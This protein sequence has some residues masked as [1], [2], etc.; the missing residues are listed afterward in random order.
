[1]S[2]SDPFLWFPRTKLIPP[3][4]GGDVLPRPELAAALRAAA[5]SHRLTLLS[6]P[7]GSGKT[8]AVAAL[9]QSYPDLPLAWITLDAG[10]DDPAAFLALLVAALQELLPG[11]A[12]T[13]A[14]LLAG[15]PEMARELRAAARRVVGALVNDLLACDPPDFLLVLDD[16]HVLENAAVL[17]ALDYLLEHLPPAMH[18]A[19]ACRH[20]PALSL[21]RLRAQGHLAEFRLDALRL[22]GDE[23]AR[24][25]NDVMGLGLS[26]AHLRRLQERTEGWVAGMRLLALS[27]EQLATAERDRFIQ[28]FSRSHRYIFDYLVEEVWQQQEPAMRDFL[29]ETSVL[30][31]L[32]PDLCRSVTGRPDAAQLLED[33]HRRNLFL[34]MGDPA[35]PAYR[36]HALFAHFLRSRL[37]RER[38][39]AIRELHRRAAQA[40][41]RAARAIPHYLAAE[42]WPF[43]ARLGLHP[44]LSPPVDRRAPR[45]R[46]A[47]APLAPARPR[48]RRRPE[49]VY[50]AGQALLRPRPEALSPGRGQAG[51][52]PGPSAIPRRG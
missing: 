31:E 7:A 41:T 43:P 44:D 36:Y 45:E 26:E 6:A 34:V 46:P 39:D 3:Q 47:G 48:R 20:D 37:R 50:G 1:M 22:T 4:V 21:A 29:L 27:L 38:P 17:R 24:W 2:S 51:R 28:T 32:T 49:R 13:A 8:T 10:D 14:N 9:P 25:L 33:V 42:M 40:T 23:A 16:L 30:D 18:V 11:C 19:A 52:D 35:E 5:L 12:G 15:A